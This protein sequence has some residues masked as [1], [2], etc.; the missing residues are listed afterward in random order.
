MENFLVSHLSD[1]YKENKL[2]TG[3]LYQLSTLDDV[4]NNIIN[5]VRITQNKLNK[6]FNLD[7]DA[8]FIIKTLILKK[9]NLVL[10][11]IMQTK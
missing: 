10:K 4:D 11:M 7:I 8:G 1:K 6:M 5:I 3:M 9:C 2:V